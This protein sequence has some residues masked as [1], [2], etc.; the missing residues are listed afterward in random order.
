MKKH[1]ATAEK[2]KMETHLQA[3]SHQN[4]QAS[5][6]TLQLLRENLSHLRQALNCSLQQIVTLLNPSTHPAGVDDFPALMHD[7]ER[8]SNRLTRLPMPTEVADEGSTDWAGHSCSRRGV[9][10]GKGQVEDGFYCILISLEHLERETI[11]TFTRN[12]LNL[13]TVFQQ[14]QARHANQEMEAQQK[15]LEDLESL[16]RVWQ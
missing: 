6:Q 15:S 13:V 12:I 7:E 5:R 9:R 14:K 3:L 4:D 10:Q 11:E 8:C 16:R 2:S 1:K